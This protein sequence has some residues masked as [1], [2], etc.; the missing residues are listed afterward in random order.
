MRRK[1]APW[2]AGVAGLVA[3]TALAA[4]D[5]EVQACGGFFCSQVPVNQSGEQIV[6]AIDQNHVKAYIQIAFTGNAKDFAW[7]V[8]VATQPTISVG[9]QAVFT[10][11][12][13]RTRPQFFVQWQSSGTNQCFGRVLG[14]ADAGALAPQPGA[15]GVDILDARDVGPYATVTL[16]SKSTD[17]LVK[18]LSDNGYAQ[19]PSATP[20]IKHYVEQNM[21][22]VAL[23]LKQDATVGEITP[24]V[25]DMDSDPEACVP[26]IL[27]Q[28]AATVNMPVLVYVL[29]QNRAFPSNWFHVEVNERKINWM[30]GGSNYGDLVNQA[31]DEAAGHG[32]VTE[33][34]GD[35]SIMKDALY[36]AGR[37]NV[38]TL[39]GTTDPVNLLQAL[40]QMGYPRDQSMQNLLRKYIPMPQSLK[41]RGVDERSFYNNISAYK[42]DLAGV[43]VDIDAFI[44]ELSERIIKPVKDAQSMFDTQPYLTRL[45][46]TVSPDEMTRD[47]LFHMNPDLPK[48]SNIHTAQGTADCSSDGLMKNIVLTLPGGDKIALDEAWRPYDTTHRWKFADA[49]SAARTIALVGPKG[50]PVRY[51]RQQAKAAD[52][53]LDRETPAAV[54]G[55]LPADL[56]QQ[57]AAAASGGWC[58]VASRRSESVPGGAATLVLAAALALAARRPQRMTRNPQRL[59]RKS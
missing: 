54:R 6:F 48:V 56:N 5:R 51:T 37:W 40:L 4:G 18:W 58:A 12:G 50:M 44:A 43:K 38:E 9:T 20:L 59:T 27:T 14:A 53:F 31:I 49:E 35:S 22:F 28:V 39:R 11:L 7:V 26:L 19:P 21:L 16:K 57:P 42:S 1:Q 25:L 46:S 47:P 15:K 45:F 24:L 32:F 36:L 29:N 3:A 30:A 33:Y 41:D 13:E 55:R 23:R 52:M 2:L 17:E 8:P 34:A 10:Q